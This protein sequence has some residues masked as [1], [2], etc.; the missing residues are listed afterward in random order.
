MSNT[1][2][3]KEPKKEAPVHQPPAVAQPNKIRLIL[4]VLVSILL[5]Y[6]IGVT[7]V[8][9]A[10]NNFKPDI[11][12]SSKEPPAGVQFGD[13]ERMW[14]VLGKVE[15]MYYDKKAINADKLLDGAISGMVSSLDDP[16]TMYLPPQQNTNFKQSMAGQFEGIGAE[17]GLKGKDIIVVSPLDGS[18][19]IKAGIKAQDVILKVDGQIVVGMNLNQVVNKIRGKKGTPVT[20]T[21]QRKGQEKP[22]DVKIV[23]D[24][25]TV[26][27]V[28][29]WT[30]RVSEVEDINKNAEGL[31]QFGNEKVMYVRLAQFGNSANDEWQAFAA[32]A[33]KQLQADSSI[34]GLIFDLRNNPGG[35]L[36]DAIFIVS[37]FVP[38]G[39][40]VIREDGHGNQKK[41]SV[42]GNGTLTDVPVVVLINKGSASAAEITAG[43]LRD[44]GRATLVGENSFGK[45][46]VQ[47]ALDLGGGAGL[48]V[49][50]AKWLTP[51]GT[52]VGNGKNGNG[53]APDV[54]AEL[55][56]K[57]PTRDTQLEKAIEQLVK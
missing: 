30:K 22:L 26:K 11:K 35:F 49:T 10:I 23:R 39:V 27:S 53:L 13:T 16:Y 45:G 42:T 47:Q 14:Q 31:A 18:P 17:L 36:E 43:G 1:E 28:V 37:E 3:I 44:N 24:T 15:E 38:S 34:K 52:W 46:T 2:E 50:I 33:A 51:N 12:I 54:K 29:T 8:S 25:I 21:V 19:A 55:D 4:I 7:K 41:E 48:H 5:G 40:A 56:P 57:N 20:V 9:I 32:A 6:V